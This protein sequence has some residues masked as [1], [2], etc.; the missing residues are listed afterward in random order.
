LKSSNSSSEKSKMTVDHL[1]DQLS[2]EALEARFINYLRRTGKKVTEERLMILKTIFNLERHQTAREICQE[3]EA[4][5]TRVSRATVYRTLDILE[6]A[7]L[8][9][10]LALEGHEARYE[11]ALT[12]GHHDHIICTQCFKI[13]EFYDEQIEAIQNRILKEQGFKAVR[14]VHHIYAE[15]L[16]PD[17]PEKKKGNPS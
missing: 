8:I 3:V 6:E 7:G 5:H 1:E 12:H 11:P 14:H 4:M 9:T 10:K 13:L 2:P 17:C 15:C 16:D